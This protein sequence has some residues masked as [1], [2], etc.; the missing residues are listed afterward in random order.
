MTYALRK[1]VVNGKSVMQWLVQQ[2]N[3]YG[4]FSSTQVRNY[5]GPLRGV[6]KFKTWVWNGY[7]NPGSDVLEY[8]LGP[9]LL[10]IYNGLAMVEPYLKES[11][12]TS[13]LVV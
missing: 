10:V 12:V 9:Y 7:L 5:P 8:S 4:G 2:R 13:Q 3:S 11:K 6:Q 1:D